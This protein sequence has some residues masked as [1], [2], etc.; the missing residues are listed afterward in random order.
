MVVPFHLDPVINSIMR[1]NQ[2]NVVDTQLQRKEKRNN[3]NNGPGG[4][5]RNFQNN[6][7]HFKF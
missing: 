1:F 5:A 7:L 4:L 3:K 2:I 6:L